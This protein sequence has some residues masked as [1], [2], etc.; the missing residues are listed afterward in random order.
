MAVAK[1][2]A[3]THTVAE[4]NRRYAKKYDVDI[5]ATSIADF[6][7]NKLANAIDKLDLLIAKYPYDPY[8]YELKGQFYLENRKVELAVE[9]YNIAYKL[10][11]TSPLIQIQL[12]VA[13]IHYGG[14]DYLH[15]AIMLLQNASNHELDNNMIWKQISVAYSR[16]GDKFASY[17]AL[18]KEAAFLKDHL[19]LQKHLNQATNYPKSSDKF[20]MQIYTDLKIDSEDRDR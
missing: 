11:P 1:I 15:K 17:I 6:R 5:Y 7:S 13:L 3:Y 19:K 9:N 20:I 14:K 4:T 2:Y 18:A 8:I 16:I 10:M 12:A